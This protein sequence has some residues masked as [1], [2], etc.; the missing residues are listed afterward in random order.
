MM[1]KNSPAE[2]CETEAETE[3]LTIQ[4]TAM[5]GVF[6]LID[7]MDDIRI[8]AIVLPEDPENFYSEETFLPEHLTDD[9]I[10]DKT[11]G[12]PIE[13]PYYFWIMRNVREALQTL[14]GQS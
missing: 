3:L 12:K 6:A 9:A 10:L 1:L 7:Y 13:L 4:P 2:A 14:A 8:Q 5:A 11:N